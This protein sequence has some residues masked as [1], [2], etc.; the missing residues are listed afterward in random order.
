M[1]PGLIVQ[2]PA[3]SPVRT[4]LP[5]AVAHVGW[6]IVPTVGAAGVTGCAL[7]VAVAAVD[8]QVLSAVLLTSTEWLPDATP[9]KVTEAW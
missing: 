3:G 4:T 8:T 5:V 9:L 1:A 2:L 6:V 7:T